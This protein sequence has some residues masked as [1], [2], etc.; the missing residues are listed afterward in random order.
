MMLMLAKTLVAR[1]LG[2]RSGHSNL[3][4]RSAQELTSGGGPHGGEGF[5]AQPIG[6]AAAD[7]WVIV[8]AY[9]RS[10]PVSGVTCTIGGISATKLVSGQS[11]NSYSIC[12]FAANVPTGTTADINLA[13]SGSASSEWWMAY[14]TVN[15]ANGTAADT[16]S[17]VDQAA[18]TAVTGVIIPSLGFA[19]GMSVELENG[20]DKAMSVDSGFTE[21]SEMFTAFLA[22]LQAVDLEPAGSFS[23]TVTFTITGATAGCSALIASWA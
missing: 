8:A 12:I 13:T 7:R 10:S 5:A 23:G 15:M 3:T 21:R 14:W 22:N 2:G 18:T 9:V 6:T 11:V 1:S 16:S 17:V 20:T 4:F 19:V